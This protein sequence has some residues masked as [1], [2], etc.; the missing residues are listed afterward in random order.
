MFD[1]KKLD[2]MLFFD[3]ETA[4]GEENFKTLEKENPELAK[5]FGYA[6]EIRNKDESKTIEDFYHREAPLAPEYLKIAC[7]G[8]GTIK[9][10]DGYEDYQIKTYASAGFNETEILQEVSRVFQRASEN[11]FLL[12]GQNIKDFDI[13]VLI[14]RFIING[15]MVPEILWSV[16]DSKPWEQKFLDT[17]DI[18]RFGSY[19]QKNS[20]MEICAAL[21][22]KSPKDEIDGKDVRDVYYIEKDIDKIAKYCRKDVRATAEIMIKLSNFE[23]E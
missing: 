23:K 7:F 19:G 13:P 22:I 6:Y 8:Y 9:W 3:L 20:L 11:N 2:R 16:V 21:G 5:A 4:S 14:K 15:M 18:W 1:V 12:V 10:G 17:K